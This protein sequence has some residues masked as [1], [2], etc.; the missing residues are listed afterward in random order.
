LYG[1]HWV[2]VGHDLGDAVLLLERGH[3]RRGQGV[4]LAAVGQPLGDVALLGPLEASGLV[5]ETGLGVDPSGVGPHVV[6][7]V[8]LVALVDPSLIGA[9]GQALLHALEDSVLAPVVDGAEVAV[10]VFGRRDTSAH[11]SAPGVE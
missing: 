11:G 4:D 5:D 1:T 10:G 8:D 9:V 2:D 6:P 3:F 7:G